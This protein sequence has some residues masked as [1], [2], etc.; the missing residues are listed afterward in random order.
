MILST[1]SGDFPIPPEVATQLPKVPAVP[2]PT[3]PQYNEA[4][5]AF[6]EWLDSAPEHTI[7]FERL[8]RWH[9]VQNELAAAAH[10][11][12]R[13]FVVTEDGLD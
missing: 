8:R 5:R 13:T 1:S 3:M 10:A 9:L 6:A 7:D 11:E 12:G 4:K 2:D